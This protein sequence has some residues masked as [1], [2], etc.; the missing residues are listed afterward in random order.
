MNKNMIL[1][2]C[3]TLVGGAILGSITTM[4]ISKKSSNQ[5]FS[6]ILA[7]SEITSLSDNYLAKVEKYGISLEDYTNTLNE[8]IKNLPVEQLAQLEGNEALFN[9]NIFESLI[10]Q[11]VV[12]ATAVEEG[13]LEKPE[14]LKLFRNAAQ[15]ALLNLYIAQNAP[16]DTNAFTPSKAQIDQAYR[17]FG[18]EFSARGLNASQA[19]EYIVAQLVQQNRQRWILEFMSKIREKFRIERNENQ[20]KNQ[21]ISSSPT[22]ATL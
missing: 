6:N 18:P 14:N 20:M 15:Q 10:N 1:M 7:L 4:L 22:G 11:T 17:Q 5:Q 19:R 13:F 21:N 8:V 12:V 16:S 2:L 9:A 3:T